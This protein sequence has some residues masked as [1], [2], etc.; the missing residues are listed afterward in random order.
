MEFDDKYLQVDQ[1]F[2]ELTQHL[3][4]QPENVQVFYFD[5]LGHVEAARGILADVFATND[6]EYLQLGD[7]K[8]RLDKIITIKGKPGPAYEQYESIGHD[9]HSCMQ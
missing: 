5:S 1:D 8:V 4:R 9:C 6:G 2:L 3:T 7:C